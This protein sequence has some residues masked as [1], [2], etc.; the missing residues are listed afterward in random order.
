[1]GVVVGDST[2]TEFSYFEYQAL[3]LSLAATM[4]IG[5]VLIELF[6]SRFQVLALIFPGM[7]SIRERKFFFYDMNI[8]DPVL[9]SRLR[10]DA[11]NILRLTICVVLSYLW[12]HCVLETSQTVGTSFPREQCD[13]GKDC[14]ASKLHYLTLFTRE[15]TSVDCSQPADFKS[16]VVITCITFVKPTSSGWLMHLAIGH[17]LTLLNFKCYEIVT[18]I[19]GLHQWARRFV[20]LLG[21]IAA[22]VAVSLFFSGV[23]SEFVSSWLAFVTSL[24]VPSFCFLVYQSSGAFLV[25]HRQST[26][27]LQKAIENHMQVALQDFVDSEPEQRFDSATFGRK[28]AGWSSAMA[29]RMANSFFNR[30]RDALPKRGKSVHEDAESDDAGLR[31]SEQNGQIGQGEQLL[32]ELGA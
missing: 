8:E 19:C 18:W 28:H 10:K 11:K 14:F 31:N 29:K 5:M 30:A 12:E 27:V 32:R 3:M 24:S 20:L 7:F 1:M 6:T 17:S 9:G 22:I 25:L 15:H 4:I 2:V 16:Q 21:L 23:M 13:D 26:D